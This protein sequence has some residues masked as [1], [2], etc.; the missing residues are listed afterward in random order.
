MEPAGGGGG[1]VSPLLGGNII[2]TRPVPNPF[3]GN[4]GC[5]GKIELFGRFNVG[6][7][8]REN[9]EGNVRLGFPI[10]VGGNGNGHVGFVTVLFNVEELVELGRFVFVAAVFAVIVAF[11]SIG[12]V[13]VC[14]L[15][16]EGDVDDEGRGLVLFADT[17]VLIFPE[18]SLSFFSM[19]NVSLKIL[20]LFN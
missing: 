7:G 12:M 4:R 18:S 20:A 17:T 9:G 16:V 14:K 3:N 11:F 19:F 6:F 8:K 5:G 1:I 2:G 15:L 13:F 10:V